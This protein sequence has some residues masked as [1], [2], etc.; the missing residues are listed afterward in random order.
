MCLPKPPIFTT[1]ENETLRA[2]VTLLSNLREDLKTER[3]ERIK[4]DSENRDYTEKW[5][6]KNQ[7]HSRIAII[8]S[9]LALALSV[10]DIIM[11]LFFRFH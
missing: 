7:C 4:A 9:A 3:E 8:V 10:V 2:G 5:N 11:Q 1:P 6:E